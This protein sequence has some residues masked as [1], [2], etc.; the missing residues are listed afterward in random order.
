MF[1]KVTT[2]A[3]FLAATTAAQAATMT[4]TVDF[5]T[6]IFSVAGFDTALGTLTQVDV[7]LDG[8]ASFAINGAGITNATG[9]FGVSTKQRLSLE[10]GASPLFLLDE[11]QLTTTGC[12]SPS[13]SEPCIFNNLQFSV[14]GTTATY[15]DP[16][17]L[18]NFETATVSGQLKRELSDILVISGSAIAGPFAS[19]SQ[20]F[21]LN[22]T[23]TYDA[24]GP[25]V[26]PLPAGGLLLL[27]GIALLG[28]RR[29][30]SG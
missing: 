8:K 30:V 4:E 10:I 18:S 14:S 5:T 22:V 9:V 24:S 23:Y 26:V 17:D 7:A 2:A 1:L 15:T 27:S 16:G 25:G 20:D 21:T 11:T 12:G 29:A 6:D 3:A 28:L 19:G 13:P